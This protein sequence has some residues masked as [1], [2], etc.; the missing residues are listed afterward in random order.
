M[1]WWPLNCTLKM[2]KAVK[3]MLCIFYY[4]FFKKKGQAHSEETAAVHT[5]VEMDVWAMAASGGR[6]EEPR[7][8]GAAWVPPPPSPPSSSLTSSSQGQICDSGRQRGRME[9]TSNLLTPSRWPMV[10]QSPCKAAGEGERSQAFGDRAHAEPDSLGICFFQQ[11]TPELVVVGRVEED[12]AV[13][14]G[15]KSVVDHHIQPLTVLPELVPG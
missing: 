8:V 5:H 2:V 3:C 7:A 9:A 1:H 10:P 6:A 4:N 14:E 11:G 15:G 12:Q 13:P